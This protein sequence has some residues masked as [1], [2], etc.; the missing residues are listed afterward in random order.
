MRRIR[1]AFWDFKGLTNAEALDRLRKSAAAVR[2]EL[3]DQDFTPAAVTSFDFESLRAETAQALKS[4]AVRKELGKRLTEVQQWLTT[5][6][7]TLQ[8]QGDVPAV[9]AEE[10]LLRALERYRTFVWEVKL[11]ELLANL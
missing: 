4:P 2:K 3:S 9:A 11:A 8:H 1:L 7:P 5:D 10:H 6:A